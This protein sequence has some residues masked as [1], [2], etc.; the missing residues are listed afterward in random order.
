[1]NP[2][3]KQT[4]Q[5]LAGLGSSEEQE[6]KLPPF[7][8]QIIRGLA[9]EFIGLYSPTTECPPEFLWSSFMTITA[10]ALSPS[11]EWDNDLGIQ[12]RLFT[13]N[14]GTSA[15]GRKST[16]ARLT[17]K[18][19]KEVLREM[20]RA[21]SETLRLVEG[22]G[23]IEGM[24]AQLRLRKKKDK[25]TGDKIVIY[26]PPT[27]FYSDELD[28]II[29]RSQLSGS[30]GTFGI[31]QLLDANDLDYPLKDSTREIRRAYMGIIANGTT[32]RFRE[33]WGP[34]N[35]NNGFLNRA[36]IVGGWRRSVMSDPPKASDGGRQELAWKIRDLLDTVEAKAE[37]NGGKIQIGFETPEA[38]KRWDW[39]YRTI[40]E[41]AHPV[42]RRIDFIGFRL[43]MI[44]S[45]VKGEMSVSIQTVDEVITFLNY[46][47]ETRQVLQ[48]D[49]GRS[50]IARIQT[51]I[52]RQ[53]RRSEDR[54]TSRDLQRSTKSG[55]DSIEE[56]KQALQG[57]VKTNMLVWDG[58]SHLRR[59]EW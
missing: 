2:I 36:M 39:Y 54:W 22:F 40:S 1:M 51:R 52:L 32:P 21:F 26:P 15:D 55:D 8:E 4:E 25:K 47:I 6:V 27:I 41:K 11:V 31:H 50:P 44:Q 38:A 48:P 49:R 24:M 13:V 43:M 37:E 5:V 18:L 46:Q 16:G 23:S 3:K 57:L 53:F 17:L 9:R 59:V 14:V 33:L 19:W 10:V 12:P 34:E 20:D 42:L 30:I 58:T 35:I 28:P 29:K 45:L 7:F 56:W